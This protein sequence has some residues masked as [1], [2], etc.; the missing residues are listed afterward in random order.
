MRWSP[1]RRPDLSSL[2]F[3]FG[4][5]I[6]EKLAPSQINGQDYGRA[7]GRQAAGRQGITPGQNGEPARLHPIIIIISAACPLATAYRCPPPPPPL[8]CAVLCCTIYLGTYLDLA[9]QSFTKYNTWCES[10]EGLEGEGRWV[11]L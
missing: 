4:K 5:K 7:S 11:I 6:K 2:F 8:C 9:R 1:K 3:F 10:R